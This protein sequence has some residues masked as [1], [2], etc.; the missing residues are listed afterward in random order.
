MKQ[1]TV[2]PIRNCFFIVINY[3]SVAK[4][5]MQ[6]KHNTKEVKRLRYKRPA[7]CEPRR[8]F[9][10]LTCP[11]IRRAQFPSLLASPRPIHRSVPA[12]WASLPIPPAFA[13]R[14][15]RDRFLSSGR[16]SPPRAHASI[17]TRRPDPVPSSQAEN[18]AGY[19]LPGGRGRGVAPR[20]C[21]F[22]RYRGVG[23]SARARP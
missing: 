17:P 2:L 6:V 16:P 21:A 5:A 8:P 22:S 11:P 4:F 13:Y 19:P 3:S 12:G 15:G 18:P 14:R 1:K 23:R 10:C 9:L 20:G 7:G